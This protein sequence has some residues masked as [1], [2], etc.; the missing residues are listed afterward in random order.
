[1]GYGDARDVLPSSGEGRLDRLDRLTEAYLGPA[2]EGDIAAAVLILKMAERRAKYFKLDDQ[3]PVADED[4][5]GLPLDFVDR[6]RE[7]SEGKRSTNGRTVKR[8]TKGET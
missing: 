4:R 5:I 7:I 6:L 1:M 8:I 2:L 3:E